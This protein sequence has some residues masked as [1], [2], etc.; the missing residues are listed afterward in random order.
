MVKE[1]EVRASV[2]PGTRMRRRAP[3]AD[4]E[5]EYE[6]LVESSSASYDGVRDEE[7]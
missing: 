1:R 6:M 4:A 3:D 5:H 7:G 2:P